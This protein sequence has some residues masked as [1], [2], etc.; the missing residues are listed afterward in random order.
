M[1]HYFCIIIE[2]RQLFKDENESLRSDLKDLPFRKMD[3]VVRKSTH[4]LG[5]VKEQLKQQMASYCNAT[6]SI[7][8]N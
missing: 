1:Y 6:T 7:S 4:E 5:A 8:G 3:S 2:A